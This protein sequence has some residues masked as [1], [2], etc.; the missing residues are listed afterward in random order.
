MNVGFETF[1]KLAAQGAGDETTNRVKML[2]VYPSNQNWLR[3][4][5]SGKA[6]IH[7][8]AVTAVV[9]AMA[10]NFWDEC[11]KQRAVNKDFL[12]SKGLIRQS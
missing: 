11:E 10:D 12:T 3:K 6:I 8:L 9:A 5:A 7:N 1:A 4:N 2:E